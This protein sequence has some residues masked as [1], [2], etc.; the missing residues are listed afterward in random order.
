MYVV[1]ENARATSLA[2][3]EAL[4]ERRRT[5]CVC[6]PVV[7]DTLVLVGDDRLLAA[8]PAPAAAVRGDRWRLLRRGYIRCAR[9]CSRDD[10]RRAVCHC[11]T[12]CCRRASAAGSSSACT[13]GVLEGTVHASSQLWVHTHNHHHHTRSA[14]T[15]ARQDI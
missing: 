15:H 1:V 8:P 3:T 7:G 5:R 12:D 6:R 2:A 13:A 11:A 14:R 9:S 4:E 10:S